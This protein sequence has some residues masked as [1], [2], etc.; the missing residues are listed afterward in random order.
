MLQCLQDHTNHELGND[1]SS[2]LR[3]AHQ[4]TRDMQD[5]QKGVGMGS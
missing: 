1:P 5:G 3:H 2:G 4:L